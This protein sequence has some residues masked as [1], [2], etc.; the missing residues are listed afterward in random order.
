MK[1]TLVVIDMQDRFVW[2]SS[3]FKSYGEAIEG[4]RKLILKAIKNN[5]H[6]IFVEFSYEAF[7]ERGAYGKSPC[8]KW[9]TL[10]ELTRLVDG[11]PH[12]T[13][14]YKAHQGGGAEIMEAVKALDIPNQRYEVCGVYT[15]HCVRATVLEMSS[16][17]SGKIVVNGNAVADYHGDPDAQE[18]G[19]QKMATYKNV[20]VNL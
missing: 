3:F 1:S 20:C 19:L 15:S 4:V 13:F 17:M 14:V 6:I 11:Y 7:A 10:Q 16:L 5:Q 9:P 18:I 12:V 2:R 8:S